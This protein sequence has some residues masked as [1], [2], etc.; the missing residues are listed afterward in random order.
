LLLPDVSIKK[1]SNKATV[2]L[3]FTKPMINPPVELIQSATFFNKTMKKKQPALLVTVIPSRYSDPKNLTF[4]YNIT[5]YTPTSL[6][7]ELN[8][9]NPSI[10][11][12][13][14]EPDRIQL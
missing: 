1:V 3:S 13:F 10:V 14:A 8:F 6:T 11:S 7:L 4:T 2:T 9:E 12:S 5:R